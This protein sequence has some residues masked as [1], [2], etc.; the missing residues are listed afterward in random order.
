M[1]ISY[2]PARPASATRANLPI[3]GGCA[4]TDRHEPAVRGRSTPSPT[5]AKA[6]HRLPM[7]AATW[8][9]F[10]AAVAGVVGVAGA[11]ACQRAA[12]HVD[13]GRREGSARASRR[14]CR[15]SRRSTIPGRARLGARHQRRARQ[16]RQDRHPHRPARSRSRRPVRKP[17]RAGHG[18]GCG[19]RRDAGDRRR[20]SGLQR[21]RGFRFSRAH[22]ESEAAHPLGLYDDET[23]EL[24]Q[25]H[26]PEA[27]FLET[28]SDARAYD[29]TVTISSR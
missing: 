18:H 9:H 23:S 2:A 8:K 11:P 15:H 1:R 13:A 6:D 19:P 3:A 24:C 21:A 27:H 25:W 29:G 4:A 5:G 12:C 10:A 26:V 7:R 16:C 28:W 22:V 20:Q 17:A 14:V